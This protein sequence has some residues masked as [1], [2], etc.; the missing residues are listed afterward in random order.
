MNV[1]YLYFQHIG[2]VCKFEQ[3]KGNKLRSLKFSYYCCF[4]HISGNAESD[5]KMVVSRMVWVTFIRKVSFRG[6]GGCLFTLLSS[7]L[8]F[9]LFMCFWH[10]EGDDD[11]FMI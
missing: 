11:T 8:S 10:C 3:E 2:I 4:S 9:N 5:A 7:W 1:D 6:M